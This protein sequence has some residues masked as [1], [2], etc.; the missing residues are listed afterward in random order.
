MVCIDVTNDRSEPD[1]QF[2]VVGRWR[3]LK[4]LYAGFGK[5]TAALLRHAVSSSGFTTHPRQDKT[6]L[7]EGPYKSTKL[8]QTRAALLSPIYWPPDPPAHPFLTP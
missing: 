2:S 8:A 3:Q 1:I 5:A 6:S 4:G 7:I